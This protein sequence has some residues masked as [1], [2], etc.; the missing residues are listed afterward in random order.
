MLQFIEKS[1]RDLAG[2]KVMNCKRSTENRLGASA[3]E[4]VDNT[5]GLEKAVSPVCRTKTKDHDY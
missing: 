2:E 4:I 3:S 1:N 5:I